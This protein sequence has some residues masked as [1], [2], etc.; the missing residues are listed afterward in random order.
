MNF[1]KGQKVTKH[2][3]SFGIETKAKAKVSRVDG[4]EVWLS[5]GSGNDESGPFNAETGR[6]EGG[7]VYFTQFIRPMPDAT[8]TPKE[9]K[10]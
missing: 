8:R 2:L 6:Y 10:K 7:S 9:Q 5:N 3:V 1:A 4:N